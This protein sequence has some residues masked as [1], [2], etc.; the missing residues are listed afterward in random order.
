MTSLIKEASFDCKLGSLLGLY[1]GDV[2]GL[3][4]E[5]APEPFSLASLE[6]RPARGFAYGGYSDDTEMAIAILEEIIDRGTIEADSLAS[7]FAQEA[8]SIGYSS[9]MIIYL[10]M[11]SEGVPRQEAMD[12]IY[13][14]EGSWGNGAAM[15]VAPLAVH[16]YTDPQRLSQEVRESAIATHTHPLA[17]DGAQAL[18]AVIAST[19][20]GERREASLQAAIRAV[21]EPEFE[22]ALKRI[23]SSFEMPW[24]PSDVA[25]SLGNELSALR[26]VPGAIL[27]GLQS[28]TYEEAYR[29]AIEMGGDTD[30]QAAMAGAIVGARLG[31]NALDKT[32]VDSLYNGRRGRGYVERLCRLLWENNQLVKQS[33]GT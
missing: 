10:S 6:I 18:A 23:K 4:Y 2:M 27:C 28:E 16:F 3:P 26:S 17:I 1:V 20:R 29:F 31:A 7:R 22:F 25:R 5:G 33:T 21:E 12:I 8:H 9:R 24:S 15:R 19:L 11:I 13:P 30:T 14:P 32:W